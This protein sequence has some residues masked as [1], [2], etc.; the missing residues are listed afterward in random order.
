MWKPK[1][2]MSNMES[3]TMKRFSKTELKSII[4]IL[5][6]LFLVTS[7]NLSISLRRG[8]DSIRKNDMSAMQ[9][10]LDTYYQKYRTFPQSTED[11][12]II[13]CFD[14][15][16]IQDK[17]TG[18]PLNPVPCIW[19]E[20]KFESISTLVRDPKYQNGASYLYK[21]VGKGY[22]LYV[23]LEGKDEAEYQIATV[24]KNLQ[25]GTKICNYGIVN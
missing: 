17:T 7:F 11:G 10:A 3:L 22:E 25:C 24:N 4:L 15:E 6:V 12:K 19:G 8:R 18:V 23:S 9:N 20:S 1:F 13:G 21:S 2:G 16:V 14:G 5:S